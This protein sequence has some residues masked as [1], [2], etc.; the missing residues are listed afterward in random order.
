M[1]KRLAPQKSIVLWS[2]R[3]TFSSLLMSKKCSTWVEGSLLVWMVVISMVGMVSAKVEFEMTIREGRG[4]V[5]IQRRKM[6][7]FMIEE[8][9]DSK[10]LFLRV[11]Y[12][13]LKSNH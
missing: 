3:P 11:Y 8:K 2:L 10:S 12:G 5:W 9:S 1:K 7:C 6:K 4:R 13:L